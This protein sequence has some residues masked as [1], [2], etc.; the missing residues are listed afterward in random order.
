MRVEEFVNPKRFGS[1]WVIIF[2]VIVVDY[3]FMM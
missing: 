1:N 3:L 2:V